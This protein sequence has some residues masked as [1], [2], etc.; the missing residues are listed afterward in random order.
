MKNFPRNDVTYYDTF[1]AFMDG[2][3][4]AFG[5]KTAV[6]W[7]LRNRTE[8][9]RSFRELAGEVSQLRGAICGRGLAGKNIAIVGENSYAWIVT[10]LAVAS[11]GG[12]AV[13][14]DAEQSNESIWQMMQMAEV[15]AVF[16]SDVCLPICEEVPEGKERIQ[17]F[18][19]LGDA[20]ED[21]VLTFSR[22]C[23]EG[24]NYL[25]QNGPAVYP[26]IEVRQ[27]AAIAFTSGT[28][29]ISK[30][31]MLS[32]Q[33]I[34]YNASDSSVYVSAGERVFTSLPFY[35]TYGMTCAVLATLV[36]GAALIINGDLKTVM[37]DLHL[38]RAESMLTVPLMIEAIHNQLWLNAEREGQ[39]EGLRRLLRLQR[40]L[41]K[42][43][44][45]TRIKVLEDVR[46]KCVGTLRTIICGGAHLNKEIAEE[47]LMLGILV[48]QGYGI[49]ECS[50]LVS[51]NSNYSYDMDSV[52]HVLPHCEVKI[53]NE[54]ILV[55]GKNVMNGYYKSPELTAEVMQGE[56]FKTGDLGYL[57]R[58]GFLYITGRKKNL[59]VFKNGKKISPE[60]LEEKIGM[61]PLVKDVLVYGAVSGASADDVKLAA[62][63]YPDPERAKGLS[64]Y[65]ILEQ[66]QEE[67]NKINSHLPFYQQ[68][69]MVNIR[70]QEFSKTAS[71]KIKRHMV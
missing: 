56:R 23:E 39:E 67:I 47:F 3:E 64:S 48:L 37:R 4:K 24:E 19:L 55:R 49:T 7:F 69:Q 54:E 42:M 41:R 29:S 38:S 70:E 15:E 31:V 20:K 17:M 5:D 21:G 22:L 46:Q 28:T 65:E 13:C 6:S 40:V 44:I 33:A 43:G 66:L 45:K 63:I 61:I 2:I 18:V 26:P 50:P 34:L 60:K 52:G 27:T 58:D 8:E 25:A 10:Y 68:V 71:K 1:D 32:N 53:E 11:C 51:V 30:P 57:G 62:S 35:H 9:S 12:T 36:R 14:I 59:I 16:A